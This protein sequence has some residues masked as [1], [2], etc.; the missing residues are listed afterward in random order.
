MI[1]Q[2]PNHDDDWSFEVSPVPGDTFEAFTDSTPVPGFLYRGVPQNLCHRTLRID[3]A[4][5]R[6]MQ[7]NRPAWEL[8]RRLQRESSYV[9]LF[10]G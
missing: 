10:F 2:C 3:S 8:S 9:E 6:I 1:M 4:D 7:I 5:T